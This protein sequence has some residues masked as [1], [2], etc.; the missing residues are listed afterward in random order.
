MAKE[1]EAAFSEKR[2]LSLRLASRCRFQADN[3]DIRIFNFMFPWSSLID[4]SE[5]FFDSCSEKI[6]RTLASLA[7]EGDDQRAVRYHEGSWRRP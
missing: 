2:R 4:A 6:Q 1:F 3:L 7:V 5:P